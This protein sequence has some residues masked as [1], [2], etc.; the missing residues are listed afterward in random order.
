MQASLGVRS[1]A[2]K[3]VKNNHIVINVLGPVQIL[4]TAKP[5]SRAW[6]FEL[7]IYVALH[8]NGVKNASWADAL[9]PDRMLAN[10]TIDSTVSHARGVLGVGNDG[11][12]LLSRRK[13]ALYLDKSVSCDWDRFVE[14]S[15]DGDEE[16]QLVALQLVRGRPFEGLKTCDWPVVEGVEALLQTAIVEVALRAARIGIERGDGARAAWAARKGLLASPYDERL[17]RCLMQA[18]DVEG[19]PFGVEQVKDELFY[20]LGGTLRARSNRQ[21][22]AFDDLVH[23]KTASL[24]HALSRQGRKRPKGEPARL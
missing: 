13:G 7:I 10:A 12:V 18:A 19:H 14:L 5:F 20:L 4:G 11:T 8:P 17:Y 15:F 22:G 3:D 6:S 16:R 23:P 24:Y 9:C 21:D 1:A 2:S